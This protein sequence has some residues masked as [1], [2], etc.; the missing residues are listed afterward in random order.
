MQLRF[1]NRQVLAVE[2]EWEDNER[3]AEVLA[4][5]NGP[6]PPPA[7]VDEV[8]NNQ[9][10]GAPQENHR[11]NRRIGDNCPQVRRGVFCYRCGLDDATTRHCSRCLGNGGGNQTIITVRDDNRPHTSINVKGHNIIALLDSFAQ[12]SVAGKYFSPFVSDLNL[13]T[14]DGAQHTASCTVE[15]PIEFSGQ[16]AVIR[17]LLV[18]SI[19]KPLIGIRPII[20]GSVEVEKGIVVSGNCEL[21]QETAELLKMVL[22]MIHFAKPGVLSCTNLISHSIDTGSAAPIKQRQ[23]VVSPYLQKDICE[24]IDRLLRIGVI[25]ACPASPWNNPVV[26]V[27]KNSGAVRLCLD[28][29]KL[30]AVTVKDAYPT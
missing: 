20:C 28:A 25:Y 17:G 3:D 6:Q 12:L 16:S 29:R 27:R 9:Y 8:A 26:A 23:Y 7:R 19:A 4:I 2:G 22:K 18:P 15:I 13:R 11:V 24:E 30:N 10:G 14:A 21:N 1:D 5:I